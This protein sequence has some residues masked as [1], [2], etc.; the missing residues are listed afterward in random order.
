MKE[1]KSLQVDQMSQTV[2][3]LMVAIVEAAVVVAAILKMD[4]QAAVMMKIVAPK[5]Q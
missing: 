3:P 2:P 4:P 1:W 5:A